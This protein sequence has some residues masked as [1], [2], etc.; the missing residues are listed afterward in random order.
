MEEETKAQCI[1]RL[2][3]SWAKKKCK[4]KKVEDDTL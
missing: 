2:E 4:E 3:Y 1:P